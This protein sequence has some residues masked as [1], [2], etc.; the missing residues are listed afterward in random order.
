MSYLVYARKYRPQTFAEILGQGPIVT[1]LTNA[2][3]QRRVGHAYLFSGPRGTG[4]TSTA[5]IFAKSLNCQEGPTSTP[6]LSCAACE[7]IAQGRSLDVLEIDGASNRGIDQIRALRDHSKFSPAGGAYKIY[8][9]DE[10]HQITAEGFNA[11][12]KIL[13]EPPGHVIFILATT[14]AHKVPATI[15]SRC[16]RYEFKRLPSEIISSKIKSIAQAEKITIS[17]EAAAAIARAASGSLR[18]AESILDQVA[19]FADSSIER[20]DLEALL[21][22]IREDV[23]VEAVSAVRSKEPLKL[24]ELIS[25]AV[26]DGT[27]LIQWA[28]EFLGFLRDLLVAKAGAG[29][30]GF[31]DLGKESVERL[32]KLSG[33]FSLEELTLMAQILAAATESMRRA[34]DPRVP[35]EIALIRLASGEPLVPVAD[36]MER[37]DRL[38]R[39][40]IVGERTGPVPQKAAAPVSVSAA[41]SP[42]GAAGELQSRWNALIEKL[43][44]EKASTAANLSIASPVEWKEGDPPQMVIEF[45]KG[46]QFQMEAVERPA[47]RQAVEEA[48]LALFGRK[49]RCVF[50]MGNGTAAP[51]AEAAE[52]SSPP[53]AAGKERGDASDTASPDPSV[54]DSVVDLFEGRVLPGGG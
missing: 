52:K 7:E 19:S 4:K 38:G 34:G 22:T 6:C 36:L 48:L 39:S 27:D 8:I 47:A 32:Q 26:R 45:P 10:V 21:G 18:D 37:L 24:L 28:M 23:F 33:Q 53:A 13:E 14:A 51:A 42:A 17:D 20:R 3:R 30:A 1:T 31:E 25:E 16:Q 40:L 41:S 50:R 43:L 11:L 15:L 46:S 29:R 54:I 49:V 12:L 5:R 35:L 44:Q 2:V 9:I